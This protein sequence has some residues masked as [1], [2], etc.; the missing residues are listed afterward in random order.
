MVERYARDIKEDA[1]DRLVFQPR[2]ARATIGTTV[3]LCVVLALA[4]GFSRPAFTP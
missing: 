1:W 3:A 2:L 4:G